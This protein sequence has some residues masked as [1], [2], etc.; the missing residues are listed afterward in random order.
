MNT[1]KRVIVGIEA[2]PQLVAAVRALLLYLLAIGAELLIGYLTHLTDPRWLGVVAVTVPVIR[3]LEGALDRALKGPGI[4]DVPP[5]TEPTPP[6][7]P[8]DHI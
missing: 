8:A 4:N 6:T 5:T 2:D 3:A 7:A 1:I